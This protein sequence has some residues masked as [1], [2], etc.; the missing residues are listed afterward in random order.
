MRNP[1]I[2]VVTIPSFL[3][4]LISEFFSQFAMNLLNFVL[5]LVVFSLSKSNIAVAGVVL[6][7]TVPSI[8]F[9]IL[10]GV[11]VD[12]WNKK[13]VL[14]Y[15]N[16]ARALAVF[17]LLY[18]SKEL[19]PVYFLS[20]IVSLI[21]QFFIPAETPIIPNLVRKDLLLS[22]NALFSMGIFGSIIVA[23]AL[24]GPLLLILGTVNV[25]ILVT[26]LFIFSAIFAFLIRLKHFKGEVKTQRINILEEIKD[27]FSVMAK[28]E[29]VYHS[30]FLLTILQ[31]IILVIAVIGPGYANDVLNIAVEKFPI[32]F[33][34][35]AVIGMA[36]GAILIGNFLHNKS[37]QALAKVGLLIIGLVMLVFPYGSFLTSREVV[38]TLNASLP[39]MMSI[40]S[41]HIMLIMAVMLGF[42]FSLVFVPSTTILQE[43]TSD[44]QRGKVYG[45]LNTLIG[46]VSIAPILG[47]GA[48]ADFIGVE[49]VISGIGLSIIGLALLRIFKYK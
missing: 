10:A 30:L 43:E 9:G 1:V 17:P 27:A 37:K 22:A 36:I 46:V 12:N 31:T 3:F 26:G 39:S 7:F 18:V 21:T 29:K 15:T 48:L 34:T 44:R 47:V 4:L 49:K 38:E 28:K 11:Y 41:I 8:L 19:V 35:P 20:F 25:F 45:S 2:A 23:Y 13:N 16:L 33:V 24:S 42:A 14:V 40:N 6:S 5:L 32:L